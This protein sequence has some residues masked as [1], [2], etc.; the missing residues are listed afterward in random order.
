MSSYCCARLAL[1]RLHFLKYTDDENH[2]ENL[3]HPPE[4]QES[5]EK[6]NVD[7]FFFFL[8]LVLFPCVRKLFLFS[9]L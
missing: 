7:S 6:S 5:G 3:K 9:A 2:F 1:V 4:S 8:L